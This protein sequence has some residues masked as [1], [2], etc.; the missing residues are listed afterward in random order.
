ML[1]GPGLTS[2]DRSGVLQRADDNDLAG[3]RE[4]MAASSA[5]SIRQGS[6]IPASARGFSHSVM[7]DSDGRA[8]VDEHASASGGD[9]QHVGFMS[10]AS[11]IDE[12]SLSM[13]ASTP[14]EPLVPRPARWDTTASGLDHTAPLSSTIR[15]GGPGRSAAASAG[16]T[17]AAYSPSCLTVHLLVGQRLASLPGTPGRRT[18]WGSR[19]PGSLASTS[20]HRQ[21][22]VWLLKGAAGCEFLLDEASDHALGPRHPS[23]IYVGRSTPSL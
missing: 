21:E 1:A 3:L 17:A 20:G 15:S 16:T 6:R 14:G 5:P 2:H 13:T 9:D 10:R 8:V 19:T 18:W 11:T 7:A 22:I 12:K 4:A 23:E